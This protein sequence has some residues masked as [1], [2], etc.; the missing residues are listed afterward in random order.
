[1]GIE[2]ITLSNSSRKS[3]GEQIIIL[4]E[5]NRITDIKH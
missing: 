4:Q 1:M 3:K 5:I 2:G